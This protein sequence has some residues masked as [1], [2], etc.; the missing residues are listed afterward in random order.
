MKRLP[1]SALLF[2]F[3]ISIVQ[4]KEPQSD[5]PCP[6]LREEGELEQVAFGDKFIHKRG[7]VSA[8][9]QLHKEVKQC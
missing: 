2:L 3:V 1:R 4:G 5:L 7:G 9:Q 6:Y 8:L